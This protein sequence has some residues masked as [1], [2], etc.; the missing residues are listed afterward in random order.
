LTREE[1]HLRQ[2]AAHTDH[3]VEQADINQPP[4]T[5]VPDRGRN[6][7]RWRP[8]ATALA[9]VTLLALPSPIQSTEHAQKKFACRL[10]QQH[11]PQT[12]L[13]HEHIRPNIGSRMLHRT[14]LQG[15]AIPVNQRGGTG[16]NP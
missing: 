16:W 8:P 10:P 2:I 4:A 6:I 5:G 13:A 15:R 3:A 7:R 14:K 12:R 9:A 11:N 1:Y